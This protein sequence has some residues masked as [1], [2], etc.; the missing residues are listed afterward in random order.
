[1]TL[2]LSRTK[3]CGNGNAG[4]DND[5][6]VLRCDTIRCTILEQDWGNNNNKDD[7]D[8]DNE[9]RSSSLSSSSSS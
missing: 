5:D 7:N 8:D 9:D 1:M 4:I 6:G 2:L 3:G